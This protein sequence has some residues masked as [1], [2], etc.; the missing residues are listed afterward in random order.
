[1]KLSILFILLTA[2]TFT[3]CNA[4]TAEQKMDAIED[5]V[6]SAF[7]SATTQTTTPATSSETSSSEPVISK[8]K[9]QAIALEHAGL[10]DD[11]VSYL[12]THYEIDNGVAEYEVDFHYERWEYEYEIHAETGEI[13]SFSRDE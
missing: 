3:G 10:T 13:I 9:A 11:Q 1:M 6:E 8:D 2:L 12:Y 7:H 4:R 5:T